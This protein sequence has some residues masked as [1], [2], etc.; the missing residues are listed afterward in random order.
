MNLIEDILLVIQSFCYPERTLLKT[1]K[2]LY[3]YLAEEEW[4]ARL[5]LEKKEG[6]VM[7]FSFFKGLYS[8]CF[9][10]YG[11]FRTH[12]WRLEPGFRVKLVEKDLKNS[13]LHLGYV[14]YY[15][16]SLIEEYTFESEDELASLFMPKTGG[17]MGEKTF[18]AAILRY[19]NICLRQRHIYYSRFSNP[20][21][22]FLHTLTLRYWTESCREVD[23]VRHAYHFEN[24][25]A[26]VSDIRTLRYFP[27]KKR[28]LAHGS[29]REYKGRKIGVLTAITHYEKGLKH[30]W[31][32]Q[33]SFIFQAKVEALIQFDH[34]R[35]LTTITRK[36]L[37]DAPLELLSC[38]QSLS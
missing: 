6:D 24:S 12:I 29:H 25:V 36:T 2:Q 28:W 34:S 7:K 15:A 19:E 14:C 4:R 37:L 22:K 21:P 10:V 35:E 23:I 11:Q 9:H 27:D 3:K 20:L 5:P 26:T 33:V 30:G 13:L 31:A 18:E 17:K 38:A 8:L 32:W 16:D 1:C